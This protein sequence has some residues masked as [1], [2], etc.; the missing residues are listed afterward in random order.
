MVL[1]MPSFVLPFLNDRFLGCIHIFLS[2]Y[3]QWY[4]EPFWIHLYFCQVSIRTQNCWTIWTCVCCFFV[5]VRLHCRLVF[6]T[7]YFLSC[8]LPFFPSFIGFTSTG[9]QQVCSNTRSYSSVRTLPLFCFCLF[10]WQVIE[11]KATEF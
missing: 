9:H 1:T 2:L 7:L 6:T 5:V 8:F 10:W 4:F 11:I 3:K